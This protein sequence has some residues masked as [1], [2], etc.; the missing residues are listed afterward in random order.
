MEAIFREF[1]DTL[2][3]ERLYADELAMIAETEQE[4]IKKAK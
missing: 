4:L 1:R 2:P 3:C